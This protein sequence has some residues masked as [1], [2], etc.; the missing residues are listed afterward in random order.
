VFSLKQQQRV[1]IMADNHMEEK[2]DGDRK[3]TEGL[4]KM[5]TSF[6]L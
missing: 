4:F 2:G 3:A 5:F 6:F 1:T